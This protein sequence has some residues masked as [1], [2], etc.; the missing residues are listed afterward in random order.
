MAAGAVLLAFCVQGWGQTPPGTLVSDSRPMDLL[1]DVVRRAMANHGVTAAAQTVQ[2]LVE[3]DEFSLVQLS[4]GRRYVAPDLAG[5]A[6]LDQAGTAVRAKYRQMYAKSADALL[7]KAKRS[8]TGE[9][10]LAAGRSY[11]GTEASRQARSHWA[12]IQLDRGRPAVA[13]RC[14]ASLADRSTDANDSAQWLA[15]AA[16]AFHLAGLADDANA[17]ITRLSKHHASVRGTIAAKRQALL[18]AVRALLA[19]PAATLAAT[20]RTDWPGPGAVLDGWCLMGEAPAGDTLAW[21]TAP[22]PKTGGAKLAASLPTRFGWGRAVSPPEHA[23]YQAEFV[24]GQV[25]LSLFSLRRSKRLTYSLPTF[26]HPLARSGMVYYRTNDRVVALDVATG[27]AVWTSKPLP[28]ERRLRGLRRYGMNWLTDEGHYR[29]TLGKGRLYA[30][31]D[32]LPPLLLPSTRP[33]QQK[34]RVEGY[35]TTSVLAALDA[36]TGKELWR[37]DPHGENPPEELTSVAMVSPVAADGGKV[38][39]VAYSEGLH[40]FLL[41]ALSGETG[42]VRWVRTLTQ[43]PPRPVAHLQPHIYAAV[44]TPIVSGD[45]LLIC[46]NAGAVVCCSKDDGRRRWVLQYASHFTDPTRT[47]GVDA[48]KKARPM[49]PPVVVDGVAVVLPQDGEE[50]LGIEM[51]TGQV[52]WRVKRGSAQYVAAIGAG[53]VALYGDGVQVIRAGDGKRRAKHDKPAVFGRPICVPG[54]AH[55]SRRDGTGWVTID[56]AEGGVTGEIKR[57][58][59]MLVGNLLIHRG[60]WIAGNAAGVSAMTPADASE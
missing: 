17:A 40:G 49:V 59:G 60:R 28:M 2:D 44:G 1:V 18:P 33:G 24:G 13:G 22:S 48:S 14:W 29:L 42:R 8:G 35:A 21:S 52:L 47:R 45:S 53:S 23:K 15:Q 36:E 31:G 5:E 57:L 39:G 41:Y 16:V 12:A 6:I 26:I 10:F 4:G 30:R 58:E 27:K 32:F 51:R 37:I 11:P 25:R 34:P 54:A 43:G 20:T 7:T 56:P 19:R 50:L 9:A 46:T 55:F 3:T 38:Y